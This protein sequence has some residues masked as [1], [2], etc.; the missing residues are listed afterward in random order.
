VHRDRRDNQACRQKYGK[1]WDRYCSIVKYRCVASSLFRLHAAA[2]HRSSTRLD[3]LQDCAPAILTSGSVKANQDVQRCCCGERTDALIDIFA[4]SWTMHRSVAE[5]RTQGL[6][7]LLS[8]TVGFKA[9]TWAI[10]RGLYHLLMCE[11]QH[12]LQTVGMTAS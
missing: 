7:D 9:S 8:A 11:A 5:C 1:D 3:N 10:H 4:V 6:V 2:C 12:G